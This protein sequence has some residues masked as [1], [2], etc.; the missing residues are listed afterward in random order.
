MS[1][2]ERIKQES[3]YD[4][5]GPGPKAPPTVQIGNAEC[6]VASKNKLEIIGEADDVLVVVH[7]M[8]KQGFA[9]QESGQAWDETVSPRKRVTFAKMSR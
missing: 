1:P 2:L 7:R 3:I 8:M 5:K 6:I 4:L 9:V